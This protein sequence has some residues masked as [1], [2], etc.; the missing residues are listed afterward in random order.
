MHAELLSLGWHGE[1][2][3]CR[4]AEKMCAVAEPT[5]VLLDAS[6]SPSEEFCVANCSVGILTRTH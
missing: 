5:G 4:C 1:C 6:L 3:V 2:R